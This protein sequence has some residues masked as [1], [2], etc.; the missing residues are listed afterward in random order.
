MGGDEARSWVTGEGEGEGN[1]MGGGWG[2]EDVGSCH[3][4]EGKEES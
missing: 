3:V 2:G 1:R 4:V